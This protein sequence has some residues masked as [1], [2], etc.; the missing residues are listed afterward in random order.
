MSDFMEII[1]GRRSIRKFEEKDIPEDVMEKI[2]EAVR[3]S[4]SWT[5]SQCWEVVVIKDRAVREKIQRTMSENNPS[6][7]AIVSAPVLLAV[8]GKL[9]SS[10]YYKGTAPTK[11]GDWFMFDLG[12]AT[13]NIC[14]T[15]HS[16]G[17]GTVVV[18]LFDHD[19][20]KEV[21][22]V[23]AGYELVTLIP[24]GYPA[25]KPLVPKRRKISDFT[26]YDTF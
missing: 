24:L 26:H 20:A 10:G 8:C 19:R 14:L 13:Q 11:F 9:K 18:G 22:K 16:L 2:L 21:I 17:L 15:A 12:L 7:G 5:N 6:T 1:K 3:Y 4:Q 25:Q 23:P